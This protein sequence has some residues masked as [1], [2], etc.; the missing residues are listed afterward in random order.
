MVEGEGE[1]EGKPRAKMVEG[2]GENRWEALANRMG[3]A[4]AKTNGRRWRKG[5][6]KRE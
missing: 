3:E 2:E 1:N 4:R 5:W 6:G